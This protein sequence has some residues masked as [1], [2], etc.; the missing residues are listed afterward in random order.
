[1]DDSEGTDKL[2]EIL[3][4]HPA[5][6]IEE[7]HIIMRRTGMVMVILGCLL[8]C[9]GLY[10]GFV[11]ELPLIALASQY[12]LDPTDVYTLQAR[13]QADLAA[14]RNL[15]SAGLPTAIIG[16]VLVLTGA[17]VFVKNRTSR[18]RL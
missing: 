17:A 1:M 18:Q 3:R 15:K 6:E 2:D 11:M 9:L 12:G 5:S 7:R 8:L 14:K 13:H 10:W 16:C 4:S